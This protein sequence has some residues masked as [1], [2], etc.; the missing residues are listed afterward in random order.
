MA[1]FITGNIWSNY[2]VNNHK[3]MVTTNSIISSSAGLVMGAGIALEAKKIEP[4]L[5]FIFANKI[6]SH[7]KSQ[8]NLAYG[9]LFEPSWSIGAFQSKYHFKNPSPLELVEISANKLNKL[10]LRYEEFVFNLNFPAVGLG[11]L[12]PSDVKPIIENLPNNV[13]IWSK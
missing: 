3:I 13:N 8:G 1:N 2:R 11:G 10:A 4:M 5:P 7:V 6:A 9:V 12:R